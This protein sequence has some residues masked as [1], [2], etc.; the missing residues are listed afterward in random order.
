MSK[1]YNRVE[2]AFLEGMMSKLG[3]SNSWIDRIM[4][5]VISIFF[6]FLVN[7]NICGF[8]KPTRGLR[9]GDP[10]SPYLFFVCVKGLSRLIVKAERRNDIGS[11]CCSRGGPKLTHLFFVDDSMIFTRAS[12][13]DCIAIKEVLECYA[14]AFG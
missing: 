7:R 1:V 9:Q 6:F 5:C 12:E 10:L 2:W 8:I 14:L 3:F 4:R 13:R 11:F